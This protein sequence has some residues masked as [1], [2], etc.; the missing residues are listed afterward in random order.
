MST[1]SRNTITL[2]VSN[3]GSAILS[4][5]LSVVIGRVL[6]EEGLGIY[7]TALAWVFPLTLVAEFGLGT[8]ITRD[9]AQKPENAYAYLLTTTRIRLIIGSGLILLTIGIAPLLSED[10]VIIQGIQIAAPMILILPFYGAFTAVFRAEQ[11]ML[12]IAILNI[13]MLIAQVVLTT[14]VFLSGH[15]VIAAL[16]VNTFTSAGQLVAAWWIYRR[17]FYNEHNT[18]KQRQLTTKAG[19]ELKVMLRRAY[20][21]AIAAILAA[22]QARI[23][24]I[25]LEQFTNIS[26]V[27]LYAAA[28][29]FVE[30]GRMLP[31]ALFGALFPALAV[32]VTKPKEI[33]ILFRSVMSGLFGFGLLFGIGFSIFAMPVLMLTYGERF[34]P[35]TR[36]L[37]L[38]AWSLL[39]ALLRAGR[40]LYWYALNQESFVNKVTIGILIF[41]IILS[42][43]I[44]PQLGA[45]GVAIINL[46]IETAALLLLWRPNFKQKHST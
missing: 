24:I 25:L 4:F 29:R 14:L 46:I 12:P 34:N 35:A 43:S 28:S 45:V 8:L 9:V 18:L 31:N 7:T 15:G 16:V 21:F 1:L 40:T 30:A 17:W 27:G 33:Q 19:T 39:P 10:A 37:Q 2:L 44:I 26:E 36:V 23:S 42:V 6:G 32:V 13:G 41:Q 11:I 3:G 20:P 22:L 5:I 38:A